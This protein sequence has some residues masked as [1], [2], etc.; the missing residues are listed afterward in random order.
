MS[1]SNVDE[2]MEHQTNA[3]VGEQDA[4]G[5]V[6]ET[7]PHTMD[8]QLQEAVHRAYS[9]EEAEGGEAEHASGI[10][11]MG[12]QRTET[13]ISGDNDESEPVGT[14]KL[15]DGS[16]SSDAASDTADADADPSY[17]N[18]NQSDKDDDGSASAS[19]GS[20]IGEEDW[21]AEGNDNGDDEARNANSNNCM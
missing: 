13:D 17:E 5:E 16:E 18:E 8:K 20:D 12:E 9:G 6:E 19:R 1:P 15:P 3:S 2:S 14:V 4:V 10:K 7:D 21:E 11:S